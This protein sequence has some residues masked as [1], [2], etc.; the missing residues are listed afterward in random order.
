[1][2]CWNPGIMENRL[3]GQSPDFI[4]PAFAK[5]IIPLFQYSAIPS[6]RRPYVHCNGSNTCRKA[7][8]RLPQCRKAFKKFLHVSGIKINESCPRPAVFAPT[9]SIRILRDRSKFRSY[10]S[11]AA[12]GGI[13]R[14][15]TP[16]A[17][18]LALHFRRNPGPGCSRSD[19]RTDTGCFPHGRLP[20]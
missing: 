4:S 17:Y 20:R 8:D 6:G 10:S 15:Q 18:L 2:E 16:A 1:M 7:T 12:R 9:S 3:I 5:P 19:S 11:D 14:F 13:R